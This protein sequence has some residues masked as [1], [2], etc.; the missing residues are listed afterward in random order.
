MKSDDAVEEGTSDGRGCVGVAERN[1]MCILGEAVDDGEDDRLAADLGQ[2]LDEVHGNICPHL[3]RHLQG[4]QEPGRLKGFC[5][6]ALARGACAH[7]ILHQ[8]TIAWNIK[9][10]AEAMERLLDPF[11]PGAMG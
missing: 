7:P 1:K 8:R 10:S 6:V 2:P 4:L 5:L 9:I 11:M 3:G